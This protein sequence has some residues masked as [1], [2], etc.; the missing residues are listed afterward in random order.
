MRLTCLRCGHQLDVPTQDALAEGYLYCVCG[1]EHVVPHLLGPETAPNE[2]AAVSS[3]T[4]AFRAAGLAKNYCGIALGISLA[5][6][7]FFPLTLVGAGMGAWVLGGLRQSVRP[8]SGP[9]R[10]GMAIAAGLAIGLVWVAGFMNWSANQRYQDIT[11]IQ[12]MA[13]EELE[14]L[15]F[16]Q[17]GYFEVHG[18]D[19]SFDEIT[20][21]PIYG[22]YTIYLGR[23]DH[24]GGIS[25]NEA[26]VYELPMEFIPAVDNRFYR[27][28]AVTNLDDDK[29]LD[30][31]VISET[32]RLVHEVDD[33]RAEL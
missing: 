11:L 13:G 23:D 12:D 29:E 20:F 33:L 1:T 21:T 27:A 16:A 25:E 10:A 5:G 17:Q 2:R 6:I 31:W 9:R 15:H 18:R 19:G 3:R 28:V 30:V 7:V 32:G 22:R 8:H 26:M 14:K 24:V 4:R